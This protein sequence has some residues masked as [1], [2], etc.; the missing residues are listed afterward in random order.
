[1][2]RRM[3]YLISCGGARAKLPEN[4][5]KHRAIAHM[6]NVQDASVTGAAGRAPQRILLVDDDELELE[7]LADRL[8]V[9]R[10]RDCTPSAT[11]AP[12]WSCCR[13]NR[14]LW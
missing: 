2:R 12:R 8:Q 9:A 4:S 14:S 6:S 1:M 11:A 5:H 7:L 3:G 10:L 13:L